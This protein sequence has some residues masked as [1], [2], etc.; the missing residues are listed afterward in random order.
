MARTWE[1]TW[2]RSC[3]PPLASTEL[4]PE[5]RAFRLLMGEAL[6]K[7]RVLCTSPRWRPYRG[8]SQRGEK[9]KKTF[10]SS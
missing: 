10:A 9:R 6:S 1:L 5:T 7:E 2:M 8:E 3:W 4:R